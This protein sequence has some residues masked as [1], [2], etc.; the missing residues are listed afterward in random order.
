MRPTRA[1]GATAA[2]L[3]GVLAFAGCSASSPDSA[4]DSKDEGPA[5]ITFAASILGE[6]TRGPLLQAM[7]DD[8]NKSQDKI[9]VKPASIPFSSFGTTIAT[10]LG[11]GAGPDLIAFD[12][13]NFFAAVDAGHVEPIDDIVDEKALLPGNDSM[14]IDGK[15]YGTALDIGNYALIYNPDLVKNVPTTFEELVAEAKAQTKDG[16]F[17]YAM[18]HTQAEEAGVWYD[19]S[20]FVYGFGGGWS[21][22]DGKP[23]INSAKNVKGVEAYK[24]M[25]D[26]GVIPQGTDAATYRKM[27]AE[28]KIAMMVDNGGIPTVVLGTN[29]DATLS[30]APSPLPS[31]KVGQV[32]AV[33]GVN[34]NGKHVKQTKE[35]FKWLLAPEQQTRIQGFLGGST[36]ATKITRTAEEL[37]KSPYVKVFDEAGEKAQSFVPDG[38]GVQT[39]QIRTIVVT[40]VLEA[41]KGGGDIKQALDRAQKDVEGLL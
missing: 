40:A 22:K 25:Y 37:E 33:L 2:V 20:G 36:S 39:P 23:T 14:K 19:L 29:P 5:T 7:L 8:F 27:F 30:A 26:A 31:G 6:P 4:G 34:A 18:R 15:R 11:S 10:Q 13:P 16:V 17:G 41:L 21:T 32:M 35:F 12:H 9:T 1:I 28:G 3:V 24:E 38:L